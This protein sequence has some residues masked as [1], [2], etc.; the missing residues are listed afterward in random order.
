MKLFE[1]MDPTR[2]M[3]DDIDI[4]YITLRIEFHR[5]CPNATGLHYTFKIEIGVERVRDILP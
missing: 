3:T 1:N 5:I 4:W 2:A